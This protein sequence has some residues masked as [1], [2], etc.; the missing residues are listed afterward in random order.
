MKTKL[1]SN[2]ER[3]SFELVV[4]DKGEL[5]KY[6]FNNLDEAINFQKSIIDNN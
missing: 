4:I 5:D 6:Y 3:T 1:K 2:K